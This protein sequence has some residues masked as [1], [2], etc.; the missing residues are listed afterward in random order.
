M[1][2]DI[3]DDPLVAK[4]PAP[5]DAHLPP[6]D[7]VSLAE[8]GLAEMRALIFELRPDSLRREGLV[9]A[10]T[11]Q[12][13]AARVRH[14]LDVQTEFCEEPAL[15][16]EVK[17]VLYRISQEALNNV[18]RHAQATRL[19]IRLKAETGSISFE[20]QD[21]GIGFDPQAEH[22]GHLGLQSIRERIVE[23][24]GSLNR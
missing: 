10:L 3:H 9:A 19:D 14:K 6:P 21:D 11:R 1:V 8:A 2:R 4:V 17:E 12:A 16:F 20:V 5:I 15:S 23:L 7:I 22:P 13:A 18:A 24:G